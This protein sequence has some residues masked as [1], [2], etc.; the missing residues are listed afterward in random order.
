MTGSDETPDD[1]VAREIAEL[2]CHMSEERVLIATRAA[3]LVSER[4]ARA[5]V[6][7]A[8]RMKDEFLATL[9]HE[10]RTPLNAILGWTELLRSGNLPEPMRQQAVEIIDRNARVQTRLIEDLLEMS[11]IVSGKVQLDIQTVE[12][13]DIIR[14]AVESAR[15]MATSKGVRLSATIE[16]GVGKLAGDPGRL[17]QVISNLLSNAIKFTPV[18]GNVRV[19][20]AATPTDLV[21]TVRDNGSGIAADFV[22]F[23]FDRFAQGESSHTRRFGGLGLGLSIVKQLVEMHGGRVAAESEG[24]GRGAT[25]TVSLPLAIGAAD[26]SDDTKKTTATPPETL[27]VEA[28]KLTGVKVLVVDDEPDSREL[29]KRLLENREAKVVTAASAAV[30]L[31]LV[32]RY[33]PDI[34]LSDIGMPGID[35]YDFIRQVRALGETRGGSVPAIAV[36]AFARAEDRDR[37]ILAGYQQHLPKPMQMERLL[38][39]INASIPCRP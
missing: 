29:M 36:T 25:F 5:E 3:E 4:A 27:L 22:P 39:A 32:E 37:A 28:R 24:A 12:L 10:L 11:R 6:E 26:A 19:G 17:Q 7:R 21:L 13:A 14:A 20:L 18:G 8:S 33:R 35:G 9:S 31:E 15:P 38:E 23:L 2:R 34:V 1:L 30:A 16:A